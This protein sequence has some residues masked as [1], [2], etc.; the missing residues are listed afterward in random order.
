MIP[1]TNICIGKRVR[2]L[3]A[4]DFGG[5]VHAGDTG[6]IVGRFMSSYDDCVIKVEWD[7]YVG[8]HTCDGLARSGFGWNVLSK[9]CDYIQDLLNIEELI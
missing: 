2:F 5:K 6:T 4:T 8:G 1:E 7:R 9:S 3:D